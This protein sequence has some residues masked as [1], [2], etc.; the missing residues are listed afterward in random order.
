MI[1]IYAMIQLN[2]HGFDILNSKNMQ[3]EKNFMQHGEMSCYK[4]SLFV[5]YISLCIAKKLH[6]KAN[7]RSLIRGALLHDYFL[8]DWHIP[9]LENRRHAFDHPRRAYENAKMDFDLT[10]CEKDIILKHMFP[11]T[12]HLP[13][14]RESY[15]VLL[16]D[17][18]CAVYETIAWQRSKR[19][20]SI[21]EDHLNEQMTFSPQL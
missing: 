8:Y 16:A 3:L 17:K 4:H 13:K 15:I 20:I 14:Y 1:N 9:S 11:L 6:I 18:Y 10:D 19:K 21:L 12:L 5:A 2:D 7:E